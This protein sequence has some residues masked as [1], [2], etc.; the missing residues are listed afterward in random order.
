[1]KYDQETGQLSF[2]DPY[3]NDFAKRKWSDD[4]FDR[5]ESLVKTVMMTCD[6]NQESA[7]NDF[8]QSQFDIMRREIVTSI[9]N[10][11]LTSVVK[12]IQTSEEQILSKMDKFSHERIT[13]HFKG[14]EGERL[15]M[16]ILQT[17]FNPFDGC[18]PSCVSHKKTKPK[19]ASHARN[20]TL[21]KR[22]HRRYSLENTSKVANSC[23]I[24]IQRTGYTDIRVECKAYGRDDPTR[25]VN[26][27]EIK[28]FIDDLISKNCHGII[29]S[30]YCGITSKNDVDIELVPTTN[31][32]AVYLS[33]HVDMLP[34]IIR[35]MYK[36]DKLLNVAEKED[37]TVLSNDVVSKIRGHISDYS[38]K[39]KDIS[40]HLKDCSRLVSEMTLSTIE[41]LL[42]SLPPEVEF[43]C[44]ICGQLCRNQKGLNQ[45]I[46]SCKRKTEA[47]SSGR[48]KVIRLTDE[49]RDN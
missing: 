46:T 33:L 14:S 37:V 30:V 4:L 16:G 11:D 35:M 34:D 22:L 19:R 23:D 47:P 1:M 42:V 40:K 17:A 2:T 13:N 9:Q 21:L 18:E 45:H 3:I 41:N 8:L 26:S 38:S 15:V 24:V 12:C 7:S 20:G 29:V 36:L 44:G 27:H 48:V 6:K 31:K 32:L 25:K 28:K 43:C 10:P 5:L 39:L 49:P